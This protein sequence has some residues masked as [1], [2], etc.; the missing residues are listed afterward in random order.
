[1]PKKL[2]KFSVDSADISDSFAKLFDMVPSDSVVMFD[3]LSSLLQGVESSSPDLAL[4]EVLNQIEMHPHSVTGVNRDLLFGK[5]KNIYREYKN[6]SFNY[7]FNT[8]RN[9]AGYNSRDV[10]GQ[11]SVIQNS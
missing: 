3:N 9:E 6:G 5:Q 7:V 4:S 1:M 2:Q 8:S 10:H 11:L